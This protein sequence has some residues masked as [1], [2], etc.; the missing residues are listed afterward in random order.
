MTIES[1]DDLEALQ[2][3]GRLVGQALQRMSEAAQPG[4]TTAEL[5][6]IGADFLRANGARSAPRLFYDFPGFNCISVNEEIVHGVPGARRLAPRD[7]LKIDVT[8]ELDGYIADT[9]LTV[10]LPPVA[11]GADRLRRCAEDAFAAA[12]KA[13]RV[14]RPVSAIGRAVDT[15]VRSQGFSVLRALCGH[16]VGRHL[17][18]EPSVP[19]FFSPLT[20]GVLHDG[21]VIAVEP[22]LSALPTTIVEEPDGWTLRTHNRCLAVHY[23]HTIVITQGE[24]IVL[25]AA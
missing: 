11:P 4:M 17:H 3:V 19:N 5:D 15:E 13:A 10:V 24:P 14:D 12:L 6:A 16:G 25:T 18:E 1:A 21:L 22:I 2:R 7:V 8:A 20:T 23:E 9:A